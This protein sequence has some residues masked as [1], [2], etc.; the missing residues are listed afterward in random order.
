MSRIRT[1]LL[2]ATTL[3][4]AIAF[5][6]CGG[7]SDSGSSDVPPQKVLDQTFSDKNTIDSGRMD[8]SLKIE[9]SGEQSGNYQI[10]VSGPFDD[11]GSGDAKL[12]L[13]ATG[14]GDIAG[15]N[16]DFEAG[17]IFTGDAGYISWKGT[18]YKLSSEQYSS[19]T[20]SLQSSSPSDGQDQGNLPGLKDS[21]GDLTN[22]G[23]TEVEGARRSTFR[24]TS[25]RPS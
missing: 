19:L 3:A 25:I 16:A 17:A 1:L 13:T 4:I 21:L 14:S 10:E 7:S 2:L 20:S 12:D 15:Q 6:A 22:E 18:D 5:A 24:A 9:A 11:N 8:A 23:E